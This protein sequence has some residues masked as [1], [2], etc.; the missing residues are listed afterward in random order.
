MIEVSRDGVADVPG[1]GVPLVAADHEPADLLADVDEVVGIAQRREVRPHPLDRPSDQILVL[2]RDDGDLDA[3]QPSELVRPDPAGVH[4]DLGI[5]RAV[6]GHHARHAAVAHHDLLH[7]HARSHARARGLRAGRERQREPG[8]VDVPVGRDELGAEHAR[9]VDQREALE[10][11]LGRDDLDGEPERLGPP[12][13]AGERLHPV[14]RGREVE[15]A[16]LM[17]ARIHARFLRERRIQLRAVHHHPRVAHGVPELGDEA[18]RVER[19]TARELTP[20]HEEHVGP[21]QAGQVIGDAG[22]GHSAADDDD[23]GAIVGHAVS[24]LARSRASP[25]IAGPPSWW[26][27]DRSDAWRT[28]RSRCRASTNPAARLPTSPRGSPT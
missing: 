4:D 12:R 15:R 22:P 9:C 24:S 2:H 26:T 25:R 11:L 13:L 1:V 16:H 14:R 28:P 17:P 7:A 8:R 3:R 6:V 10:C 5:D 20:V 18:G 23:P 27:A 19:R 21:A